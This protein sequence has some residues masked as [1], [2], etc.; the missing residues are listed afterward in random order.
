MS[1]DSGTRKGLI[2]IVT[3]YIVSEFVS[4]GVG[5][6]SKEKKRDND[7]VTSNNEYEILSIG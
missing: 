7:I 2:E 4:G 1:V 3:Q 6:S 5:D